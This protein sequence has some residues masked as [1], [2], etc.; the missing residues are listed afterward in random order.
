[1]NEIIK[2]CE[3]TIKNGNGKIVWF[4]ITFAIIAILFIYCFYWALWNWIVVGILGLAKLKLTYLQF[5]GLSFL[6]KW[7][8]PSINTNEN[9]KLDIK[10]KEDK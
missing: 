4:V 2:W 9:N 1:M 6:V 8:L 3:M 5:I 7:F 10:V